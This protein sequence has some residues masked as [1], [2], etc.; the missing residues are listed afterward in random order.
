MNKGL[1]AIFPCILSEIAMFYG[2]R[3]HTNATRQYTATLSRSRELKTCQC[4]QAQTQMNVI[5][6]VK[7]RRSAP[8]AQTCPNA[9]STFETSQNKDMESVFRAIEFNRQFAFGTKYEHQVNNRNYRET[10]EVVDANCALVVNLQQLSNRM[11]GEVP[12][13]VVL[14]N[15]EWLRVQM[16]PTYGTHERGEYQ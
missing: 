1:I 11:V 15:G 10:Y 8:R 6:N 16:G 13:G 2:E 12:E 5:E 3:N 14:G 9:N 7:L 4:N